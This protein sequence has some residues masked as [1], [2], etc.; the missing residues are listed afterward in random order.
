MV[1]S[2]AEEELSVLKCIN[3]KEAVAH[4]KH[5]K[6]LMESAIKKF[7]KGLAADPDDP[8][9]AEVM[10]TLIQNF[11]LAIKTMYDPVK[12][13]NRKEIQNCIKEPEA[14]CIW[15]CTDD[16]NDDS[17]EKPTEATIQ[18][19]NHPY[20]D[21]EEFI[22]LLDEPLSDDQSCVVANLFRSHA[23][24]IKWQGQV[25][26]LLGKLLTLLSPKTFMAILNAMVKPLHQVMLPPTVI[27]KLDPSPKPKKVTRNETIVQKITPNLE[28]IKDWADDSTKLYAAA[29]LHYFIKKTI[30]G[31]S[32]MKSN[33]TAF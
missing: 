6:H 32:N 28:L 11:K 23:C 24:K 9:V 4:E 17:Q 14:Q 25:S 3:V 8:P 22:E 15:D 21:P 13:A 1:A 5:L 18:E 31:S 27:T 26:M 19:E 7:M 2:A 10:P 12:W 20:Q 16:D 33:V 30:L 29:T